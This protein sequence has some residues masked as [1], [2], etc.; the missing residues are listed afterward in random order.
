MDSL[1]LL[2][3][4]TKEEEVTRGNL[5]ALSELGYAPGFRGVETIN[6]QASYVQILTWP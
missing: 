2:C 6:G 4:K 5:R 3:E 1:D